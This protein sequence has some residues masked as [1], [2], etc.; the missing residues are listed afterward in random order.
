MA[1][2]ESSNDLFELIPR[3]SSTQD[4]STSATDELLSAH[5]KAIVI[6]DDEWESSP[7]T[8]DEPVEVTLRKDTMI[9][10]S[11]VAIVA[12]VLSFLAGRA[13]V[14]SAKAED[15]ETRP[16]AAGADNEVK[17]PD[18][19]FDPTA[20]AE[21]GPGAPAP[22]AA[23]PATPGAATPT[24][25]T[26][27]AAAAPTR[28]AV[29]GKYELQVVTTVVEKAKAVVDHLNTDAASP[30]HGRNDLAAYVKGRS[31]RVRGFQQPEAEILRRIHK[32]KDPTGGGSFKQAFYRRAR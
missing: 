9:V 21:D 18:G 15:P 8:P 3:G 24:A 1:F 4:L 28:S 6:V 11:V 22:A 2:F 17:L 10:V 26:P 14:R 5:G 13:T 7:P 23:A 27:P 25:A 19:V 32:M 20:R 31:V 30:L 16:A 29:D 12:L